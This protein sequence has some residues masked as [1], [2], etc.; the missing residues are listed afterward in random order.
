MFVVDTNVLLYAANEA[1][2]HHEACRALVER[3]RRSTTA[4][5][6]TW[7]I[8]YEFARVATHPRVFRAPL[9]LQQAWAF[10]EVLLASPGLAVLVETDRHG[11]VA[12]EVFGLVPGAAGNLLHDAH[13]AV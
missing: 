7:G 9:T 4:W 11:E 6:A 5:Y 12:A 3:W 13:T 1:S 2:P 10:I 8:L